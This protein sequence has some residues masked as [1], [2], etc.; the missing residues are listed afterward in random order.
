MT[1]MPTIDDRMVVLFRRTGKRRASYRLDRGGSVAGGGPRVVPQ[2]SGG[3]VTVNAPCGCNPV[4]GH[5]TGRCDQN[6]N[7]VPTPS[8]GGVDTPF[9]G[10]NSWV[11]AH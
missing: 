3:C 4:T 9:P 7:C 8:N 2:S 5:C 10:G 6:L 11:I 1:S